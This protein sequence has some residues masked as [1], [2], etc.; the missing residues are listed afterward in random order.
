MF[1]LVGICAAVI[2]IV[3]RFFSQGTWHSTEKY[4]DL[5]NDLCVD[6]ARRTSQI[7]TSKS[8]ETIRAAVIR[9]E[10]LYWGELV[11]VEDEKLEGAMVDFR[12]MIAD[13]GTGSLFETEKLLGMENR[14]ELRS[15]A[16]KVSRA[17]FNLLQPNWFD[18]FK[19]TFRT[20]RKE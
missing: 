1:A 3:Y 13:S 17:C 8:A 12:S 16:L 15:A 19:S 20:L 10:E 9:F 5:K 18:Q 4:Y 2:W 6:A 14:V 7:A 11:L